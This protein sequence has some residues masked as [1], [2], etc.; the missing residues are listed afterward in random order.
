MGLPVTMDFPAGRPGYRIPARERDGMPAA[1]IAKSE[2]L[3]NMSHHIRTPI[4]GI[5]GMT[6]LVLAIDLA[7]SQRH[8][9]EIV[10]HSARQTALAPD[11]TGEP[12]WDWR[13]PVGSR[14]LWAAG[15]G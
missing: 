13:S 11:N 1:T 15:S 7:E 2:F 9:L 14:N 12:A 4:N 6:D 3:A 5:I 10:K 8:Y